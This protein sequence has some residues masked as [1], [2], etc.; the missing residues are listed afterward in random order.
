VKQIERLA[1]QWPTV[2]FGIFSV[3]VARKS[4]QKQ[5]PWSSLV[6]AWRM[7]G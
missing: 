6:E 7:S 3:S 4:R 5:K 1:A 2:H